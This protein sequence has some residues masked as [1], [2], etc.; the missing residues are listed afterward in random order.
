[1]KTSQEV[2]AEIMMENR[3]DED[4]FINEVEISKKDLPQLE[5]EYE[6]IQNQK[7]KE[8]ARISTEEIRH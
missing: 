3:L 2:Y 5:K 7:N 6:Q 1:M 4:E 8:K